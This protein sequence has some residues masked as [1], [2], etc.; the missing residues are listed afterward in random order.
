MTRRPWRL[1]AARAAFLFSS[2][3]LFAL[4]SL[5][6]SDFYT[7]TYLTIRNRFYPQILPK[8][9]KIKAIGG[10]IQIEE[11]RGN[12]VWVS[13]GGLDAPPVT[14]AD[15]ACLEAFPRLYSCR[16]MGSE[17]TDAG[18][19][20]LHGATLLHFLYLPYTNVTDKG[21]V[22]LQ[23]LDNLAFLDLSG[24]KVTD[25]GLRHL[26]DLPNLDTLQLYG[27]KITDAGLKHLAMLPRLEQLYIQGT[28]VTNEGIMKLQRA[29]PKCEIQR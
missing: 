12:D 1:H 7:T 4:P 28:Q 11:L 27:T 5:R 13:L 18:L 16:L 14:D 15:L 2:H 10:S 24:T 20:Y 22:H 29:L 17:I 9:R 19:E 3:H 23:G 21:L 25:D 6:K 26:L 8:T